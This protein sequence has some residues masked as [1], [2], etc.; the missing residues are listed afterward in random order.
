MEIWA[1]L[2]EGKSN[3]AIG[4]LL[5]ISARTVEKQCANLFAKLGVESRFAAAL[6]ARQRAGG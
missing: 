4:A 3:S 2:G 6:V 1:W 5:G